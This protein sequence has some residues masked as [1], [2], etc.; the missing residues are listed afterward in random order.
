MSDKFC[1]CKCKNRCSKSKISKVA[2][3]NFHDPQP[4]ISLNDPHSK[5]S[6]LGQSPHITRLD[7]QC[8]SASSTVSVTSFCT[9]S[10]LITVL[11]IACFTSTNLTLS[12][13]CLF[14]DCLTLCLSYVSNYCLACWFV[15]LTNFNSLPWFVSWYYVK[16]KLTPKAI[17]QLDTWWQQGGMEIP[18][19]V[20][21]VI[22]T[23][24]N[25]TN[26]SPSWIS[27]HYLIHN[28]SILDFC[29]PVKHELFFNST[30]RV[31]LISYQSNI[32]NG[33]LMLCT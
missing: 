26:V 20:L 7:S 13:F 22:W 27:L 29:L 12:T 2:E 21:N 3:Y 30:F 25:I 28:L 16:E 5:T 17:F 15:C 11:T 24:I 18:S 32:L 8:N 4:T 23:F 33:A 14:P 6:N 19:C 1:Q 31:E 10:V 9:V